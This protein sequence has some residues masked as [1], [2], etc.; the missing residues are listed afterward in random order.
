MHLIYCD[1]VFSLLAPGVIKFTILINPFFGHH[2]YTFSLSG[3][4]SGVEK[5]IFT[6]IVLFV[7]YDLYNHFLAQEPLPCLLL[8]GDV[9]TAEHELARL[10][11]YIICDFRLSQ[12]KR[13]DRD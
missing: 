10:E 3:Q 9:K 11:I 2:Y 4:C 5:K 13:M 12:S 7:L 6:E 8:Y 1:I